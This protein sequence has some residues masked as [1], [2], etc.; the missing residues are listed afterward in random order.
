QHGIPE[1]TTRRRAAID[2]RVAALISGMLL[3]FVAGSV[4]YV[5]DGKVYRHD[6]G[7]AALP[8]LPNQSVFNELKIFE[9]WMRPDTSCRNNLNWGEL[10]PEE[11]CVANSPR[12]KVLFVGDSHAMALYSSIFAK[13]TNIPS[14][15]IA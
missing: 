3:L 15:L 11:V 4:I 2:L 10:L 12:P 5:T 7:V 6:G 1:S 8:P 9:H 13:Q 14:V